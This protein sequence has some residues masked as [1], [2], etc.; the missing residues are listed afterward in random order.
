MG[1]KTPDSESYVKLSLALKNLMG[2][3]STLNDVSLKRDEHTDKVNL[4]RE[5][6]RS[7]KEIEE[8]KLKEYRLLEIEKLRSQK[9]IEELKL[10]EHRLLEIEK[11]QQQINAAEM[12]IKKQREKNLTM[13]GG[14]IGGVIITTII[15]K[16]F[17]TLIPRAAGSLRNLVTR[18]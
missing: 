1:N 16:G 11:L 8:L 3:Y 7:Q 9:E 6:L 17:E 2:P 14:S 13:V 18:V 12:D 4:E 10:K 15:E 5:K